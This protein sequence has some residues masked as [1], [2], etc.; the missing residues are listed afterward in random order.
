MQKSMSRLRRFL[1]VVNDNPN[2]YNWNELLTRTQNVFT[3]YDNLSP[4][5]AA[6]VSD[7]ITLKTPAS[8]A[9]LRSKL[10]AYADAG[11]VFAFP[12]SSFR[13]DQAQNRHS[14]SARR[15]VAR[16]ILMLLKK[17]YNESLTKVNNVNT[18]IDQKVSTLTEMI[19]GFLGT[20]FLVMPKFN[21]NNTTEV[22][23]SYT[24][25]DELLKICEE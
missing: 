22:G 23:Q 21:F 15:I 7:A 13:F 1:T 4:Q 16:T 3:F 24:S 9:T 19:K 8:V 25:Q 2:N 14:C 5:L 12:Q 20:D 11:F 10:K 6:A 18:K 17:R